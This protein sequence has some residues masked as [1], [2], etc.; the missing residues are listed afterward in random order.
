M[1]PVGGQDLRLKLVEHDIFAPDGRDIIEISPEGEEIVVGRVTAR[2]FYGN[3]V[4][5]PGSNAA[6]TID[7]GVDA[8]YGAIHHDG[9][10]YHLYTESLLEATL[11]GS[12]WL[13]APGPAIHSAVSH[14]SDASDEPTL[15]GWP[16]KHT[17]IRIVASAWYA[18]E[19]DWTVR[20]TDAFNQQHAMWDNQ[21]YVHQSIGPFM[22]MSNVASTDCYVILGAFESFVENGL[23]TEAWAQDSFQLFAHNDGS[24]CEGAAYA[25]PSESQYIPHNSKKMT[26]WIEAWD[27]DI[28]DAYNP[29]YSYHLGLISAQELSHNYGEWDHP[30]TCGT[31]CNVMYPAATQAPNM[32]FW[33]T[34]TSHNRIYMDTN[35]Q[36]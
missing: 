9:I 20:V 7:G 3:V 13:S 31:T 18:W 34:Q 15:F 26:S 10:L 23:A 29:T 16:N 6:L 1:L 12:D 32:G 33:W 5:Q 22:A 4:G 2:T 24:I 19:N 11:L 21:V 8:L 14:P 28:G 30:T 36:L 25:I 27:N 35:W 17:Y